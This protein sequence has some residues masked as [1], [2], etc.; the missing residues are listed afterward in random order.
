MI[1]FML[2]YAVKDNVVAKYLARTEKRANIESSLMGVEFE[3]ERQ[4]QLDMDE[5]KR[6]IALKQNFTKQ[7]FAGIRRSKISCRPGR[8]CAGEECR[9]RRP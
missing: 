6:R 9:G 5:V 8:H 1:R 3:E 4:P 2:A 7:T